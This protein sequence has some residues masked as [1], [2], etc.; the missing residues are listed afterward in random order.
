M[1]SKAG[2]TIDS[3][4]N[5]K[6]SFE[7]PRN[8]EVLISEIEKTTDGSAFKR[9]LKKL[10]VETGGIERVTDEDRAKNTSKV[11]NACT[12][13]FAYPSLIQISER[14]LYRRTWKG[15]TELTTPG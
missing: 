3:E 10:S 2:F 5:S 14:V 4:M 6:Q 12:F 1:S 13:W 15:D 11:W 8:D 9:W 7:T